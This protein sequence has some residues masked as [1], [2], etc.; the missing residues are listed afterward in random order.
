M[1]SSTKIE[2]R[3]INSLEAIINDADCKIR[4]CEKISVSRISCDK[5]YA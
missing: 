2:H 4:A 5:I 3:A 1:I